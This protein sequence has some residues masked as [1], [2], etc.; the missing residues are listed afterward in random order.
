[1]LDYR[2][3]SILKVAIPLMGTSF[4]QSVILITDASFLSRYSTLS[5]DAVGNGGL[6]YVTLIMCLMG[7]ADGSQILQARRIGQENWKSLKSILQSSYLLAFGIALLLFFLIQGFAREALASYSKNLELASLQADYLEIRSFALFFSFITFCTNAYFYAKGT[8]WKILVISIFTAVIN[9]GLDYLFIFGFGSFEAMGLKGAA[10]ASTAADASGAI[11]SIILFLTSK[12]EF[13]VSFKLPRNLLQEWKNLISVS[14]PIV[15]Q[16]LIALST[17]TL[18]FTWIEQ[19]SSYDLTVSQNIRSI[20]FIAFIPVFGFAGTTKTYI[21]QY[22]GAKKLEE[23][24]IIQK[25]II[26]LS[27]LFSLTILHGALLYPEKLVSLINPA[28]QYLDTTGTTLRLIFGS[29]LIYNIGSVLFQTINGSGN[30]K[31]TFV[32]E[33]SAVIIYLVFAY[34]FVKYWNLDIQYVWFVEYIYF[35]TL[36]LGSLLFLRFSKWKE[37]VI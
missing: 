24:K 36:F 8:T 6:V 14:Y 4:L 3:S 28:E 30:T 17:W 27:I 32:L 20:Y 15:F 16:G 35:G 31:A 2:Y 1:M 11:V 29:I 33:V 10:W 19:R 22:L 13:E 37:K 12:K 18:F 5:F 21:S 7:I 34:L 23:L 9:V 26:T 25:R